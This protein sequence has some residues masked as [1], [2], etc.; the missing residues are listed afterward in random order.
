[1]SAPAI[2]IVARANAVG[3]GRDVALLRG[4]IAA[5]RAAPS[6][7]HDQS[8]G[9][10]RGLLA[11]RDAGECI[12]FLERVGTRWLRRAGRYLLIPNQEWYPRRRVP[13]LAR[14]D[15]VL[16]KTQHAR[17]IFATLHPSVHFLGFTSADQG[18]PS[19]APDYGRFLHVAGG[20]GL[21]GTAAVLAVWARHP[22]W[23][24]LTV[25]RH[26][27]AGERP[28]PVPPN[29][30]MIS[31]YLAPEEL[32]GVQNACGVHL[33]PSESEGWGHYIAEAMACRAV[34]VVTDAPPMNELVAPE[35]GVR[36]PWT[37]SEPRR[38][39]VRF[40][41]DRDALEGAVARLIGMSDAEKAAMGAAGRTWFEDN[42]R[43]FR[44]RLDALLA[45]LLPG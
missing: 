45:R 1:M 13:L 2:R 41:V 30:E 5:E 17:E 21:K 35:R 39:G 15:H 25:V 38:L 6:F 31:R 43:A 42:D 24:A 9:L 40:H 8:V 11:R 3:I 28:V 37:R 36:V 27:G 23:P 16:C 12:L 10:A 44:A 7:S 14:I 29:V 33:C 26:A 22:E 32:R 19:A 34:P 18:D 20:S 4:A